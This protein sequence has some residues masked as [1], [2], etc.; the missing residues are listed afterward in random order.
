MGP[1]VLN[2]HKNYVAAEIIVLHDAVRWTTVAA[3]AKRCLRQQMQRE[4][5]AAERERQRQAE[6]EARQRYAAAIGPAGLVK[7][8]YP[9][10]T[11]PRAELKKEL[12]KKQ[13][14]A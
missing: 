4:Y 14:A 10:M 12:R 3:E 2:A 7:E 13:L 9:R 1:A 8:Q 6:E 5:E 11:R